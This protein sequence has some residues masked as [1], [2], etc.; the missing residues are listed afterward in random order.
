MSY[1]LLLVLTVAGVTVVAGGG[2]AQ[3]A[4]SPVASWEM[5]E[6]SGAGVM[7]DRSGHGLDGRVGKEVRTGA[8]KAGAMAYR[9]LKVTDPPVH[10]EHLV[11]VADRAALDPGVRDYTVTFRMSTTHTGANIIQKGQ[12]GAAGGY[13]KLENVKGA[14][15]CLFKGPRGGVHIAT[16]RRF[17][18]GAW[19][20][21]ECARTS[22]AVTLT[23]D[24][25]V[26]ARRSGRT[27]DISNASPLSIAGKINCGGPAKIT[28][29]YYAGY[30]DWVRI[31]AR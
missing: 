17:D 23:V 8:S 13:F 10:P 16:G 31:K 14:A 12:A 29:D 9:F 1:R 6:K 3:A 30:L 11:T 5:N 21:V 26:V 4:P 20:I 19:H 24:G 27:G 2:A 22:N 28:C 7:S 15:R 25:A 18:D